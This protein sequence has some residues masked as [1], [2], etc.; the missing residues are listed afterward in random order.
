ML[1]TKDRRRFFSLPDN[2]QN[3]K[4]LLSECDSLNATSRYGWSEF[5]ARSQNCEKRL[6]TA[7]Y[8]SF[9]PSVRM[10][11]LGF[12]LAEF[13]E[14]CYLS[15]FRKFVIW[16]LFENLLFEYFSKICYLS[17]F[18]KFVNLSTFRKF[19]IWVLFENLLFEYFSKICYLST[20]RKFAHRIQLSLKSEGIDGYFTWRLLYI[21]C[22]I[23]PSSS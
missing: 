16:V 14:I 13:H 7:S 15:T 2:S 22:N 1:V 23:L 3:S 21:H 18:R 17:T 11:Q 4:T 20:F 19:V 12:Q 6:F 5:L 8:L 10:E 9:L